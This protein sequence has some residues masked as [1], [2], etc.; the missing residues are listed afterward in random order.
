M[1]KL[2]LYIPGLLAAPARLAAHFDLPAAP[3]L[4]SWCRKASVRT[5]TRGRYGPLCDWLAVEKAPLAALAWIGA[6]CERSRTDGVLLATPVHFEAGMNDLVLFSGGGL[7]ISDNERAQLAED[8]TTF[9]GDSPTIEFA[10]GQLF[11]RTPEPFAVETTML[12]EAQGKTVRANLPRGEDAVTLHAWM[13]ELQMFLHGHDVNRARTARG[14]PTLNGIWFEG[15]GGLP[16]GTRIDGAVVHAESVF[17]RGLGILAGQTSGRGDIR[18]WMP[19]EGHHIVEFRDCV[20]AQDADDI[21]HWRD[22]IL[23][24]DRDVLQPVMEWLAMNRNAEAVLHAGDGTAR[25]LRGGGQGAV[26]KLLSRFA[27]SERPKVTEE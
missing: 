6:G 24:I 18:E 12:H 2:E 4:V 1:S 19:D 20:D 17:M 23:N 14:I 26:A 10:G 11:I 15:E 16:D 8:M 3:A 22:A 25:V 27:R 21:D 5:A 9:F 13:N 7:E